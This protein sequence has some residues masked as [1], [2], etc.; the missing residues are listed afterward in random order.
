MVARPFDLPSIQ[1]VVVAAVEARRTPGTLRIVARMFIR[2]PL[3]I[4]ARLFFVSKRRITDVACHTIGVG[5]S[6]LV[7]TPRCTLRNE[8]LRVSVRVA[9]LA[10]L[11]E[12]V[13][14]GILGAPDLTAWLVVVWAVIVTCVAGRSARIAPL[15]HRIVTRIL[16]WAPL[17]M[18]A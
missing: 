9:D 10:T 18:I 2:T 6:P 12:F 14:A 11:A 1:L 7:C 15:T 17:R 3:W 13:V 8:L 16:I 4:F 5:A